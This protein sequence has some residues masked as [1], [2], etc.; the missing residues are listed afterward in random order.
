MYKKIISP[1]LLAIIMAFLL[2]SGIVMAASYS[3]NYQVSSLILE[4]TGGSTIS[5]NYH[6]NLLAGQPVIGKGNSTNY[7]SSF[8][9][10]ATADI[11]VV[12]IKNEVYLPLVVKQ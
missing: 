12:P 6:A 5:A 11:V 10:W 1:T 9:F 4:G 7:K 3:T 2:I 8:G